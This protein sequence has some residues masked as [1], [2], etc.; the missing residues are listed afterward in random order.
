VTRSLAPRAKKKPAPKR[1]PPDFTAVH[2]F[3]CNRCDRLI[4][5]HSI[6]LECH[7]C[8]NHA[9]RAFGLGALQGE[10]SGV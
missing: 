8:I 3:R 4:W 7:N 6:V 9:I 2:H 5:A 1:I 10:M